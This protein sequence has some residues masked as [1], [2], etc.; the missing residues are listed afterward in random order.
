MSQMYSREDSTLHPFR[1]VTCAGRAIIWFHASSKIFH[2]SVIQCNVH[3][4]IVRIQHTYMLYQDLHVP[5]SWGDVLSKTLTLEGSGFV[6]TS[7]GETSASELLPVLSVHPLYYLS[8]L[9]ESKVTYSWLPSVSV[10]LK[11]NWKTEWKNTWP[12]YLFLAGIS[13]SDFSIMSQVHWPSLKG[14]CRKLLLVVL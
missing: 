10:L 4:T 8:I 12:E 2:H 3:V 9:L 5:S 6:P 14:L 13:N 1:K 11:V 7:K